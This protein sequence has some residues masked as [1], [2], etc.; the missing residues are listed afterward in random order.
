M[1]SLPLSRLKIME[2]FLRYLSVY[3]KDNFQPLSPADLFSRSGHN[4]RIKMSIALCRL[5]ALVTKELAYN[6]FI[7]MK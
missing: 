2:K 6:W 3:G 7:L 4:I 1:S 5:G